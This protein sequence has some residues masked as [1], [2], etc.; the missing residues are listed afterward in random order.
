M[1]REHFEAFEKRHKEHRAQLA[2]LHAQFE[3]VNK[4]YKLD[5]E[6]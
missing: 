5:L 4:R 3:E 2:T 1:E 6:S